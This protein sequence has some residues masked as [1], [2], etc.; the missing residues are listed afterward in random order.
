MKNLV[1]VAALA[2]IPAL[3]VLLSLNKRWT[4]WM[5]YGMM[6]G[7]CLYEETS[8]NFLS[9]P[10][11]RGTALGMEISLLHLLAL[12]VILALG[13]RGKWQSPL[14][15]GGIRLYALFFLLCLPSLRN[16]D[17]VLMGWLEIWKLL[18]LFFFWHAVYGYLV[19]TGD[20][21]TVVVALAVL[22]I[23]NTLK[24]IQQHYAFMWTQG[25]F[26]HK[27]TMAMA[28]NLIGPI[29]FAGYLQYG[30]GN[31]LGIIC[32]LAFAGAGLCT[33]W[34]YSRGAIVM[35]PIGYGMAAGLTLLGAK[36]SRIRSRMWVRLAPVGLAGLVG[37][38]A[39]WPHLV[40]RFQGAPTESK[41]T[42]I[43]LAHCAWEM[44]KAHPWAGVGV[45]NW[46]LNL[47]PV[48]PYHEIVEE[49]LDVDRDFTGIVET[50]YLLTG[51]E[52]GIPAL[53]AMLVWF[54]WHWVACLKA[55]W[56]LRGTRW[57]FIA[58]GLSGGLMVSYLQS[59]LEWVLRQRQTM[60]LLMLCFG[61]VAWLRTLRREKELAA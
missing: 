8:I 47:D 5:F 3:A 25:L 49:K 7:L 13:I 48:H 39:I 31:R 11:Y 15:E 38:C 51:A 18:M 17:S 6:A 50:A 27:N 16:A 19:A 2:F 44:M 30:L 57:H 26:S 1:F 61:I 12:A 52:C 35:L 55:V 41:F 34:S 23:A 29:F 56:R 53:L 46:S 10:S 33:M 20:A 43:F 40:E 22:I 37:L 42:R 24:I 60:F 4:G 14:P 45:N 59:V 28:M 58:A 54:L 9:Y 21:K 32:G 36:R